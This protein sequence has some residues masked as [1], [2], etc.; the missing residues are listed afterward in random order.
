MIA[1]EEIL[2]LC[3]QK[4]DRAAFEELVTR[5]SRL[6]FAKLYLETGDRHQAEDLLQETLLA[7]YRNL[8]QL[9][10]PAKFRSWLLRIA[11]N[12]AIDALRRGLRRKRHAEAHPPAARP[13]TRSPEEDAERDDMR[14]R[15]LTVLRG[16]PEEY[17]LPLTLRYIGGA[18]YETIQ[19]QMGLTNGSLRGLLHRGL[20]ML[21]EQMNRATE[22]PFPPPPRYQSP[23]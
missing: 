12:Q 1:N 21:R 13:D 20:Q 7:A 16:L 9:T 2:V 4:G 18:N 8:D 17:R 10:E 15:V 5:T 14:A 11:Q 22:E 23:G 19:T 6:V 3:A